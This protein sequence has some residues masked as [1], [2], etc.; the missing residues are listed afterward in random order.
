MDAA[1]PDA[2]SGAEEPQAVAETREQAILDAALELVLQ[3]G[4]D[5]LSMDALAER[6]HASKATI[7]RHWSGKAELV[8]AAVGRRHCPGEM[9][10]VDTGSLRED[11]LAQVRLARSISD[12]DGALVA[13][14]VCAMRDDNQ[15]ASVLRKQVLEDKA[16]ACRS[17]IERAVQRG[18]LS[19]DADASTLS[20]V[21]FAVVFNRVFIAG[22]S[23]DD[24]FLVH[25]V[26]DILLPVVQ[27]RLVNP[28]PS[29]K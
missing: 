18:E 10:V 4:Y 29:G 7:Y 1:P 12:E 20:E 24:A 27:P 19:E 16:A 21:M 6:A 2:R 15:L 28:Q 9:P 14:L 11:L 25:L 17:I 26:D 13:G 8:A 5:R 3:V 23:L 22:E